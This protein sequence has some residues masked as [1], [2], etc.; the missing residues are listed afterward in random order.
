MEPDAKLAELLKK[1]AAL[2]QKMKQELK[3]AQKQVEDAQRKKKAVLEKQIRIAKTRTSARE[4]KTDA[5][6]K[7]LIGAMVFSH[8]DQKPESNTALL[9]DLDE[10]LERDRDRA[11]FDLSPQPPKTVPDGS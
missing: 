7:I 10:F 5:R 8:V 6:R 4:R 11:L 9:R 2:K 1:R 3:D